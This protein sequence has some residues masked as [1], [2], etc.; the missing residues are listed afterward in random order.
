ADAGLQVHGDLVDIHLSRPLADQV[1]GPSDTYQQV[2]GSVHPE[3]IHAPLTMSQNAA[4]PHNQIVY[5][6]SNRIDLWRA[7][8]DAERVVGRHAPAVRSAGQVHLT[9]PASHNDIIGG[10]VGAFK[11]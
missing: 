11:S 2:V 1:G 9:T 10:G 3:L 5:A 6:R 7:D 8:E 4:G